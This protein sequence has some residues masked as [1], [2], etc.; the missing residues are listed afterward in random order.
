MQQ[1]GKNHFVQTR[2]RDITLSYLIRHLKLKRKL[3]AELF[4]NNKTFSTT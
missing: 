3:Y 1:T 4:C 2:L